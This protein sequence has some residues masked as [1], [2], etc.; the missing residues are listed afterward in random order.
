MTLFRKTFLFFS[1]LSIFLLTSVNANEYS[2]GVDKDYPRKLLWGDTHLHSNMSAD[3]YTIGNSNLTPS[4]AFRFARGEEVTSENG[5]RAKLRVPLDFLMVSDHATFIGMFKR[6]ENR[7]P[8][9]LKTPLGKRWRKYMDEEDP[10]LFTEFVDGLNGLLDVTFSKDDY[11]PVWKEITENV[12]SFNQ[13]GIFTALI[14]YEWTP[15]PTGDNLHR[16]VVFKDDA[17]MAQKIIPFSAIDSNKPEDLWNFL[18]EYNS[19]T[20]GEAISISHNS[21]ISGGRM[22]PL[23]NSYG[24][25]IDSAYASM[26]NRWEPLVEATQ[27]KGDSETHPILSPDDVFADYETWEGNIGRSQTKRLVR[28]SNTGDCKDPLNYKCYKYKEEEEDRYI[29]S[30]VRSGLR[31][32]LEIEKKIGTNPFKF[33]LIGSTDNHTALAASE[34]DNF[35]GKFLDSEPGPGRVESCMGGCGRPVNIADG[36]DIPSGDLWRNWQITASGYAGVWARDNTREEIFDAFKRKETYATTGPRIAVRFF[37]SWEFTEKDS[38]DPNFV[39]VGY[40]KGV[41]MGSDLPLRGSNKSPNFLIMAAKDPNGANLERVQVVKGWTNKDGSSSEKVYDVDLSSDAG[42][43]TVN[44][45]TATYKNSIGESQF[46]SFWSDP[47]FNPREQSF[48]YVRVIEIPTPRWTTYDSVVFGN[49]LPK[50]IPRSHQ[51][52]AYTSPIWYSPE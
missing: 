31:R 8:K 36:E 22:F 15:A 18:K 4:D 2:T 40:E 25:P 24:E 19:S 13:P 41:P 28:I 10:N 51:E 21:N 1:F 42:S 5:V 14:G 44:A 49:K 6:I 16:V 35:F 11:K 37:G 17:K 12:D 9:I 33:G 48:Y 23:E 45:E 34:E 32:G 26:R 20:G 29:G 43:S 38:F 46:V 50:F 39:E 47:D 3:A 52:R 27:V 7:D 30:Y